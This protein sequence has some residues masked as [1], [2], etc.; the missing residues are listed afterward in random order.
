MSL[1]V[2]GLSLSLW[3]RGEVNAYFGLFIN[4]LVNVITITILAGGVAHI[5][6]SK[7]TGTILPALGTEL[8]VGN[9]FYFWLARRLS[10]KEG[11]DNVTAMPYGPSVPHMFIVTLVIMLPT[12]LKTH[13]ALKAWEAGLAWAVHHRCDHPDRRVRGA[14]RA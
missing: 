13:S 6:E 3:R 11:R 7:V 5:P 14:H 2:P 8:L 9:C 1:S 12:Y 10:R 4:L